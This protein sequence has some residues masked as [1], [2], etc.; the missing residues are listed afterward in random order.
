MSDG[1]KTQS[2]IPVVPQNPFQF[3]VNH[4][5]RSL[6]IV[7]ALYLRLP[8]ATSIL[9]T[10]MCRFTRFPEAIPLRNIKAPYIAES[11][12]KFFILVGLP[13]LIQSV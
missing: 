2:K 11:L 5:V 7:L 10:I 12:V 9:L 3:V 6:S 13:S 4:S 1:W 8:Q